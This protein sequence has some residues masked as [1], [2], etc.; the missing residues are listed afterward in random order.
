MM[1]VFY[2]TETCD[3]EQFL[4]HRVNGQL[5][6]ILKGNSKKVFIIVPDQ[7]LLETEQA[8][9]ENIK[10]ES[11]FDVEVI[12]FKGLSLRINE[13]AGNEKEEY[14]NQ[15]TK[16]MLIQKIILENKNELKYIL[17][18]KKN[19]EV[20]ENIS[21][22]IE[23]LKAY[24]I[25]SK[26]LEEYITGS[27]ENKYM[28]N[29]LQDFLLVYKK[30]EEVLAG[31]FNDKNDLIRI[32]SEK[33][34]SLS[35]DECS[36]I[37]DSI[38]YLYQFDTLNR[39]QKNII[40]NLQK[41]ATEVNL[42]FNADYNENSYF[43]SMVNDLIGELEE[44]TEIKL[45]KIDLQKERPDD[46]FWLIDNFYKSVPN[47]IEKEIEDD[48][49]N[50]VIDEYTNACDE[51]TSIAIKIRNLVESK[52]YKYSD[53]KVLT[54][55]L[56][57]V[58]TE[59]RNV[60]DQFEIPVFFDNNEVVYKNRISVFI[61]S[62]LVLI[63][64]DSDEEFI[65]LV[66]SKLI[67]V[68]DD[69]RTF[70]MLTYLEGFNIK[71]IMSNKF[72]SENIKGKNYFLNLYGPEIY[73]KKITDIVNA[74]ILLRNYVL[75]IR[76]NF[77]N[78]ENISQKMKCLL[79][80]LEDINDEE[81]SEDDKLVLTKIEG[82]LNKIVL[83]FGDMNITDDVIIDM[84]K[85]GIIGMQYGQLPQSRD[86]IFV[87]EI[88]RSRFNDAKC[89]FF[90]NLEDGKVPHIRRNNHYFLQDETEHIEAET[91][92]NIS[93]SI[94]YLK[95]EEMIAIYRNI[96]KASEKL[97]LSYHILSGG[98]VVKRSFIISKI[99]KI[100]NILAKQNESPVY[101]ESFVKNKMTADLYLRRML[102]MPDIDNKTKQRL[103]ALYDILYK[104]KEDKELEVSFEPPN[105][106]IKTSLDFIGVSPLE[107]YVR[108]PF[109]YFV[110]NQ[111]KVIE[112]FNYDFDNFVYGN[113]LH[114]TLEE[115]YTKKISDTKMIQNVLKNVIDQQN[116]KYENL[117]FS[118]PL[119]EFRVNKIRNFIGKVSKIIMETDDP[120]T[121]DKV[122]TEKHFD[123]K[124]LNIENVNQSLTIENVLI[125]GIIDRIDYSEIE[126]KK[127]IFVNDYKTST[128]IAD[129]NSINAGYDIQMP[130]Y[131]EAVK[132]NI[133]TENDIL[134][135]YIKLK[136]EKS[137]FYNSQGKYVEFVKL[138]SEK[139]G[140]ITSFVDLDNSLDQIS[141]K[142]NDLKAGNM[143]A[144]PKSVKSHNSC[145]FCSY[146]SI[147][148]FE[149]L[150][151]IEDDESEE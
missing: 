42:I 140:N 109:S 145:E 151:H 33:V 71:Y 50:V 149:D 143:N 90:M 123:E 44:E 6:D 98:E 43:F 106:H 24:E 75:E 82:L 32:T 74:T 22:Q 132:S 122:F 95:A 96:G 100:L 1:N 116:N 57:D 135:K 139:N 60:F 97:F 134:A 36:L 46:I 117:F 56:P 83:I 48:K 26:T 35:S 79:N 146:K 142:L 94:L 130:L 66:K 2:G 27:F 92:H 8:L 138:W 55:S 7:C 58:V 69:V 10:T 115:L 102:T 3:K 118:D 61:K 28:N 133:M 91:N 14:L 72:N 29:K 68:D 125:K 34:L 148:S 113:I 53:I 150:E 39:L 47:V 128:K 70:E 88:K 17:P 40:V 30:Y 110:R 59:L 37:K 62:I 126:N 147:C 104:E 38:F 4:F 112:P 13:E 76:K 80:V 103:V 16:N 87:G 20:I 9:F 52:K 93:R 67:K 105:I 121:F 131:M 114:Q 137:K 141:K 99:E 23:E 63:E 124:G 84:L 89:I 21:N 11:L 107:Q 73:E 136:D 18:N 54:P 64:S 78:C 65:R 108:C 25:D 77:K 5:E 120:T 31:R 81:F 127:V 85:K 144:T 111:L 119:N 86:N 45:E 51:I 41:S 101:I 19:S 129:K 12:S 15:N 49:K